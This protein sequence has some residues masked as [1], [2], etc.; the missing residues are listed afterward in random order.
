MR[1][2]LELWQVVKYN[3]DEYFRSG[4][5]QLINKLHILNIITFSE[6][7]SLRNELSGYGNDKVYFIGEISDPKPRLEFIDKMIKNHSQ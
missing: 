7:K 1:T 3:F 4:L 2:Q 6:R 5:C